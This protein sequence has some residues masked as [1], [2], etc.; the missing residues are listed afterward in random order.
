MNDY[1]ILKNYNAKQAEYI[2]DA[3]N[4]RTAQLVPSQ[5]K[6]LFSP[7]EAKAVRLQKFGR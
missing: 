6:K 1:S 4:A 7:L 2:H 3:N 5:D